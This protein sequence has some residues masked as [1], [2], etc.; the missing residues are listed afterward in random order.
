VYE[1]LAEIGPGAR[2]ALP[3][4]IRRLNE[5][6]PDRAFRVANTIERI[7]LEDDRFHPALYDALACGDIRTV[8]SVLRAVERIR[9][10]REDETREL[11]ERKIL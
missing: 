11:R 9:P 7:G 8:N 10:F 3:V 6:V 5:E 2:A 4:L 1:A